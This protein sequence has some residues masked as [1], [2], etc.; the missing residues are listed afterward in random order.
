M[1]KPSLTELL[2]S[3]IRS[4]LKNKSRTF[5]T[6]LGII[7]GVTSV[8]LLTS[9]GNGLKKFVS[10]QFDSLGSNTVFIVPGQVFND[11]GGFSGQSGGGRIV[12]TRFKMT[13]VVTL[14]RNLKNSEILPLTQ[15]SVDVKSSS[16]LK[17]NIALI[18]ITADYG[19][20]NNTL[21]SKGNGRWFTQDEEDKKSNLVI[22]G[23]Q[24]ALDLF[25]TQNPLNKRVVIKGKTLKVI[26]IIDKKGSS[27][28]GPNLDDYIFTP[29][30][31]TFEFTG[32]QDLVQIL[33][34]APNKDSVET[35][36]KEIKTILNKKYQTDAFSVFDSSQLLSSINTIIGTLTI[37][38]SGIAAIS[39]I[40]GGIGIMNIMLV[41]VTER[42]REIGLRKAVGAYPRAIL[43]QFL[44]EAVILSGVGGL[45][46]ILLGSLGALAISNFF[47]ATVTPESILLAF[48]VSSVVGIIFGVAPARKASQL[49]PIEALRYE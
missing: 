47:P 28:G 31:I 43:L 40:V 3:S 45:F 22:L 1:F 9:I 39:L 30:G 35:V 36:K 26:G 24:I 6:S 37:A 42:T 25:P 4:V 16:A 10:D 49:S 20:S 12:S 34:K 23:H 11:K 7:I 33:V 48:G 2:K 21:P 14:K 18:G 32:N 41:T 5:L 44:I 17:K 19:A 46:G 13:D 8:I 27:F 15:A 29:I 38:L